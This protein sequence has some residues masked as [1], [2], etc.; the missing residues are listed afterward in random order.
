MKFQTAFMVAIFALAACTKPMDV[1]IPS[2]MTKWDKDLAPTV[3]KLTQDEQSLLQGYLMRAKMTEL[4]SKGT[5]G[6]PVGTTVGAA[7][8]VQRKWV[9]EQEVEMAAE[10]AKAAEEK[11]LRERLEQEATAARAQLANAVTA[12]LISKE[13]APANPAA[14][15]YSARQ[16]FTIGVTNKSQKSIVGVAGRL[17]FVDIFDKVV[18]AVSFGI[19]ETI[20]PGLDVTW[21]G[22]R[23]YNQFIP[24]HRAV[25]DL[26]ANSYTTRFVPETIVFSD[27][28][29]LT[30]R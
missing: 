24:A 19:T 23:D 15:H 25:W 27:G 4:L 22:A 30:A 2:D 26:K 18:G 28:S 5:E 11:A 9:A 14:G 13:E 3:K 12:A 17:E 6:I 8:A 7:I 20:H 21:H 1:V 16:R 10:R 29:K